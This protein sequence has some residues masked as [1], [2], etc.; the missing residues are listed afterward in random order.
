MQIKIGTKIKE[1]RKRDG[2]KQEDLA[3]ALGVTC[4]A[5]SRWEANGGYPD[6]ET[7]PAIANYFNVSIDELFGYSKDREQKLK[8]VLAEAE[9]AINEQGDMTECVERLRAA[10]EEFP[11][12]P[13][14]YMYLGFALDLHGWKKHGARSYTKDGSDYAFEDTEY[15]SKNVYWQEALQA[16]EKS[17]TLDISAEDRDV[18]IQRMVLYYAK[19]GYFDKAT[20]L[21]SNQNSVLMSRE[22]LLSL[23]NEGETR[24]KYQGEAII[25]IL[26]ALKTVIVNSICTKIS[27]F[28]KK[29]G[30][31]VL[32]DLAHMYESVF[33]DGRLG[34]GH[35][36]VCELYLHTAVYE[37]RFGA[38]AE[39][40]F[41]YFKK[42]F[43][44]KK[45][46]ESI[47]CRGEYRYSAPL[48]S[49][50][51]FP[52]ENFPSLAHD[53]WNG[54]M[55]VFTDELKAYIVSDIYFSECF[56]KRKII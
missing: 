32:T 29:E 54:W 4:Q 46:Y 3:N 20:A 22:F 45:M 50:V 28:T 31:A 14:V 55:D 16:F 33:S 15:N 44:H 10:A 43:K 51:T 24:D 34:V 39:K 47:R 9:K 52:S 21:A 30:V 2:R 13:K 27:A 38:G 19:M 18:I 41:E 8:S 6:M 1:L 49:K 35:Y 7:I 17:L 56:E 12:E 26:N 5:V 48:V 36:H 11:A 37:A 53:F 42:G 25:D 23:A 40:A